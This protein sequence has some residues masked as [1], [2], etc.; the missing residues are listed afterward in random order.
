MFSCWWL[1]VW[2]L[3]MERGPVESQLAALLWWKVWLTWLGWERIEVWRIGLKPLGDIRTLFRCWTFSQ[4]KKKVQFVGA[5]IIWVKVFCFMLFPWGFC[6]RN[7]LFLSFS[8][9]RSWRRG[10]SEALGYLKLTSPQWNNP[11]FPS[12]SV[13]RL[14]VTA[15]SWN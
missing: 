6:L 4:N 7:N 11:R 14:R 10:C 8:V 9:A 15:S 1:D 5:L 3:Y 13:I 2:W 12:S